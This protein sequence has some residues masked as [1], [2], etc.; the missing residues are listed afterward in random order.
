MIDSGFRK[1][2]Q[3]RHKK[4]DEKVA[5]L[6]IRLMD[7]AKGKYL[8]TLE[9]LV[10]NYNSRG[11]LTKAQQDYVHTIKKV[12]SD[13]K[14]D[15]EMTRTLKDLYN[16]GSIPP[17]GEAFVIGALGFYSENKYYTAGQK[18]RAIQ[19]IE[20]IAQGES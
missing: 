20:E 14:F 2:A 5:N 13:H 19:L 6:A 17:T 11:F 18:E 3:E 10:E 16:E 15:L 8:E 4:T 12:Y 9:S 1:R 7:T